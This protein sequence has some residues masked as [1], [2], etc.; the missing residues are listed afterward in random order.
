M[1]SRGQAK[2]RPKRQRPGQR[3]SS[4]GLVN[5]LAAVPDPFTGEPTSPQPTKIE[6]RVVGRF[7]MNVLD[8]VN[9]ARSFMKQIDQL[10]AEGAFGLEET[11]IEM[12]TEVGK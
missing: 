8:W 6:A 7:A 4:V 12:P 2:P 10:Q 1:P 5:F 9:A 11:A 3:A